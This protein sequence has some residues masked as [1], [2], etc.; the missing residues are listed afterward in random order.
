MREKIKVE[1]SITSASEINMSLTLFIANENWL[2]GNT[3]KPYL[4]QML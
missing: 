3:S 1:M 4:A 2:H